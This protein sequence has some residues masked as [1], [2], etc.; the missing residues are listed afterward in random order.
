MRSRIC[1]SHFEQ[2][3]H[4]HGC[5]LKGVKCYDGTSNSFTK[6]YA[7]VIEFYAKENNISI[8]KTLDIF[9]RSQLYE[10]MAQGISNMHCMSDEYLVQ[11]LEEEQNRK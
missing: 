7:R 4:F 8:E 2:K 1:K 10:L 6:K 9:Y 3:K 5:I 11:E